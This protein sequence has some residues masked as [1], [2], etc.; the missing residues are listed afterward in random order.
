MGFEGVIG[1]EICNLIRRSTG[2]LLLFKE[3]SWLLRQLTP[4]ST[5]RL[6]ID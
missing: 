2:R 4:Y 5:F 6:R 1:V 3:F